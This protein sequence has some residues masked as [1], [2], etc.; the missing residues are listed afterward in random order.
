MWINNLKVCYPIIL[1]KH[2][3]FNKGNHLNKL[4][5]HPADRSSHHYH[6][7]MDLGISSQGP[8]TLSDGIEDSVH[9]GGSGGGGHGHVSTPRSNFFHFRV[10]LGKFFPGNRLTPSPLGLA[11]PPPSGKSWIRHCTILHLGNWWVYIMNK[12][13]LSLWYRVNQ[14][15]GRNF[16]GIVLCIFWVRTWIN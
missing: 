9:I 5:S 15:L 8:F 11:P 12:I 14:P 10:V 2:G 16:L 6:S 1:G 7:L 3:E 4:N 13:I